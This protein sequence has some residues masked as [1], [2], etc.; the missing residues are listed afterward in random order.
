MRATYTVTGLHCASCVQK[1]QTDLKNQAD[2]VSLDLASGRLHL[3]NPRLDFSAL[4]E[5]IRTLGSYDLQE[6][7]A[8]GSAAQAGIRAYYPLIL[9]AVYLSVTANAGAENFEDWMRHFMAGFFLVFSFFKLL[10]LKAFAEGYASYDLV[11][12]RWAPYAYVYPFIELAL[13][14]AYL[15]SWQVELVSFITLVVMLVSAAGVMRAVADK[16]KLRCACLGT[17]LNV[18]LSTVTLVED[19]SMAAMA[20]IMLLM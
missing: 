9:I 1:I 6:D 2:A 19:F 4:R 13:G 16:K 10:N 11:A 15:F 5:R 17:L 12:K 20:A 14:L 18:P 3:E 7:V 8:A